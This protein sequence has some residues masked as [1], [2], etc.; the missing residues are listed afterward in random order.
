M[1]SCRTRMRAQLA[2]EPHTL[3]CTA[4]AMTMPRI[5]GVRQWNLLGQPMPPPIPAGFLGEFLLAFAEMRINLLQG[6]GGV[7]ITFRN[8]MT[9]V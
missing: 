4:V 5:R 3:V 9:G 1:V 6:P 2:L 8:P 7:I